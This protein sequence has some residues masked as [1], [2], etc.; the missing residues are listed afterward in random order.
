MSQDKKALE[1]E[2]K[3][4][5]AKISTIRKSIENVNEKKR[6]SLVCRLYN[7]FVIMASAVAFLMIPSS[8]T[9]IYIG[10]GL[11]VA[12]GFGIGLTTHF[13]NKYDSVINKY[14]AEIEQIEESIKELNTKIYGNEIVETISDNNRSETTNAQYIPTKFDRSNAKPSTDDL[15]K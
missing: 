2:K 7:F 14:Y 13:N 4:L 3:Q 8:F 11:L 15:N 1:T 10:V 5:Q 9:L 6:K 12:G